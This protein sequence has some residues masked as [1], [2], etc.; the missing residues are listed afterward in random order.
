MLN[1]SILSTCTS[2]V[3]PHTTIPFIS[4]TVC[5]W[6]GSINGLS[7]L[8]FILPASSVYSDPWSCFVGGWILEWKRNFFSLILEFFQI[9]WILVDT[10]DFDKK[11]CNFLEAICQR[12]CSGLTRNQF[13][14]AAIFSPAIVGYVVKIFSK[15]Y[16]K[17][18]KNWL[19]FH[20]IRSKV[21]KQV[22]TWVRINLQFWSTCTDSNG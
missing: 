6:T 14:I 5:P 3:V 10:F 8:C 18:Q 15:N 20:W 16:E 2:C 7:W 21:E 13:C 17:T 11:K 4:T 22:R 1:E 9:S 19:I 12:E